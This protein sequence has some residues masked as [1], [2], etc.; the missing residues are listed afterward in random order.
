M[1]SGIAAGLYSTQRSKSVMKSFRLNAAQKKSNLWIVGLTTLGLVIAAAVLGQIA[2]NEETGSN[3]MLAVIGLTLGV[4]V[5]SSTIRGWRYAMAEMPSPARFAWTVKRRLGVV[6][7]ALSVLVAGGLIISG[8]DGL[9]PGDLS[10]SLFMAI[11]LLVITAG[12]ILAGLRYGW[13]EA[14]KQLEADASASQPA[15]L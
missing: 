5:R 10:Q 15:H 8:L 6:W 3:L 2:A 14:T 12:G 9:A 13:S 4:L 1:P 7:R 11:A